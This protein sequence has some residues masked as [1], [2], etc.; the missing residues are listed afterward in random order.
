M[1]YEWYICNR[2]RRNVFTKLMTV[3]VVAQMASCLSSIL[4]CNMDDH[5]QKTYSLIGIVTGH[6]AHIALNICA[7]YLFFNNKHQKYMKTAVISITCF[8]V[9][10]TIVEI[11]IWDYVLFQ[12]FKILFIATGVW[13]TA[14]IISVL[15]A[16]KKGKVQ[17]SAVAPDLMT[18]QLT[19]CISVHCTA[20]LVI[21]SGLT[22]FQ[23]AASG[24]FWMNYVALGM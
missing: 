8:F 15:V 10:V 3:A 12:M 16:T 5:Y 7:T 22:V 19:V 2:W 11:V 9:T 18:R 17:S 21:F 6:I 4:R 24:V 13:Q 14:G 20:I 1:M 23:L